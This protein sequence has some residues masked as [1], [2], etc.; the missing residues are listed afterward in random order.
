[1]MIERWRVVFTRRGLPRPRVREPLLEVLGDLDEWLDRNEVLDGQ[2][3]LISPDGRY[4][5]TLN[6]YFEQIRMGAAP[7]NTQ[8]AHAR[9]LK[10]LQEVQEVLEIPC[11]RGLGVPRGRAH[12]N[13]LEVPVQRDVV[14]AIRADQER[15]AIQHLIPVEPLVQIPEHLQ[16]RLTNPRPRQSSPSEH[17]PPPFDHHE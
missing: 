17:D 1:M 3:F 6:R 5:V 14:P 2:P 10:N 9:D 12:P 15:L 4:D 7:W 16:Q 13:L 8:A 11:V